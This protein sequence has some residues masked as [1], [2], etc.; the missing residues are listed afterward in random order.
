MGLS[1]LLRPQRHGGV[2]DKFHL[3]R[4]EDTAFLKARNDRCAAAA[5][6][7]SGSF[8]Y[9]DSPKLGTTTAL[10]D[11]GVDA[12]RLFPVNGSD[13]GDF[14]KRAARLGA[15]PTVSMFD[16]SPLCLD[17]LG[18]KNVQLCY[19]DG[20]HG[21][22][23]RV[24]A[25]MLPWLRRLGSRAYV[26]FTFA[27]RSH[28]AL[29]LTAK[30]GL[31]TMLAQRGFEPPGGWRRLETAFTFDG[32]IFNVHMVRGLG[33]RLCE[34]LARDNGYSL[35]ARSDAGDKS[36][37]SAEEDLG[38][39][40]RNFLKKC[41][42]A[43]YPMNSKTP[44]GAE[45]EELRRRVC[46]SGLKG[47]RQAFTGLKDTA[48]VVEDYEHWKMNAKERLPWHLA[49]RFPQRL[50]KSEAKHWSR[51]GDWVSA[52]LCGLQRPTSLV[53]LDS[54]GKAAR[55]RKWAEATLPEELLKR[56]L[57]VGDPDV[58]P[59]I[60]AAVTRGTCRLARVREGLSDLLRSSASEALLR[61]FDGRFFLVFL[62]F[63]APTTYE[64]LEDAARL[65]LGLMG[66]GS[67]LVLSLRGPSPHATVA[68][69][70]RLIS[71]LAESHG[72]SLARCCEMRED[73]QD[74]HDYSRILTVVLTRGA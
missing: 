27:N 50:Q 60:K 55:Y 62:P 22:P 58:T 21:D 18:A 65:A 26:S 71:R 24:W 9:L 12:A 49:L 10:V 38:A 14:C 43:P 68:W 42:Q 72:C 31:V 11:A 66:T 54:A 63:L 34:G 15:R 8:V 57:C 44:H 73:G 51:V 25:D 45:W 32:R 17:E 74:L 64:G 53:V 36:A 70:V 4:A 39:V 59:A 13:R 69:M 56:T 1:R 47:E 28:N 2:K 5:G 40:L 23:D 48:W 19:N 35:K 33:S 29:P 16:A 6:L 52:G 7:V 41:P 30:F 37:N 61:R 67:L 3:K 20:T 46:R